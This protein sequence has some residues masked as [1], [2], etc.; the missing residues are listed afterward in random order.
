MVVTLLVQPFFVHAQTSPTAYQKHLAEAQTLAKSKG[1]EYYFDPKTR[2]QADTTHNLGDGVVKLEARQLLLAPVFA[3]VAPGKYRL[4]FKP[5]AGAEVASSELR[6]VYFEWD[7]VRQTAE[8]PPLLV[9]GLYKVDL[10]FAT[11]TTGLP[12]GDRAWILVAEPA[13]YD[14]LRAEF[15]QARAQS[16]DKIFLRAFLEAIKV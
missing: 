6:T 5:V 11:T 12:V 9:P 7:G 13:R 15:E 8:S 3:G 1:G 4:E 16:T 14:N 2:A 10:F